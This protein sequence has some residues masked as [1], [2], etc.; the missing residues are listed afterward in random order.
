[1][2]IGRNRPDGGGLPDQVNP[3]TE[4]RSVKD[5]GLAD[6]T[7]N[8][9][10]DYQADRRAAIEAQIEAYE[11]QGLDTSH[12]R[13]ILGR[14]NAKVTGYDDV[15][16]VRSAD[17]ETVPEPEDL[18]APD[19]RDQDQEPVGEPPHAANPGP[20]APR[21]RADGLPDQESPDLEPPKP[22]VVKSGDAKGAPALP[23]Q[24]PKRDADEDRDKAK[25]AAPAKKAP[26]KSARTR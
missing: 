7:P 17:G 5:T 16:Q 14:K 6:Q 4:G 8:L 3:P 13:K 19:K 1:M 10:R 25:K 18:S 26:A 9:R 11:A 2:A 22:P 12:L 21:K 23:D 20:E 24:G 15:S